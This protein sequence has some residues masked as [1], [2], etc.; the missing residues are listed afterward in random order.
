MNRRE[1]LR[2]VAILMGGAISATTLGVVADGC[3]PSKKNGE[4]F[5][6]KQ[7]LIIT[8]LADTII[9][10]T[11]TPGAKA[12][13]VGPFIAMM[14]KECYPDNV[15]K[16]FIDGLDDLEKRSESK[17]SNSFVQINATQRAAVLQEVI[18]ELKKEKEEE[19]ENEKKS[20]E[21]KKAASQ[22]KKDPGFFQLA[23]ELTMLG[24]FT[25]EIGTQQALVYSPVPGRYEG[26]TDMQPGQ[27]AWAL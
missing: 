27:K 11:S 24:Y 21:K 13:G 14:I 6:D 18:D 7:Q 1:A 10:A 20:G 17:F 16:T 15:Q 2:N 12:A 8:E 22:S 3:K 9:P 23:K 5:S 26:C 4:L 25:S 19:K